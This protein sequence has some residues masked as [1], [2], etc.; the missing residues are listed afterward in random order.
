MKASED[1]VTRVAA[2][3]ASAFASS[4]RFHAGYDLVG[5]KCMFSILPR[6]RSRFVGIWTLRM[7]ENWMKLG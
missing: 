2:F 1:R 6:I 5:Q 3:M 4:V 7:D